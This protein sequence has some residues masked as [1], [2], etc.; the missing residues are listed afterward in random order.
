MGHLLSV[1]AITSEAEIWD[2]M[3]TYRVTDF[4]GV[5]STYNEIVER[6]FMD[7]FRSQL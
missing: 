7:C 6:E 1:S 4:S 2:D 3:N 5:P